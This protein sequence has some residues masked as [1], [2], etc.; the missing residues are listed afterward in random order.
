MTFDIFE[1]KAGQWRWRLIADS[2]RI[3]ADGAEGYTRKADV[4]RAVHA[5]IQGVLTVEVEVGK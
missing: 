2:G 1:D 4:E 3:V 5:V